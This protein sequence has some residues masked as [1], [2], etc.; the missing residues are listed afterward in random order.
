MLSCCIIY[1]E[2]I[3]SNMAAQTEQSQTDQ[4]TL[5]KS[6]AAPIANTK[7]VPEKDLF[8]WKA[9]SR[10]FKRRD[11]DF[12]MTVVA[13][14]VIFGLI[15]F[16]I[17]GVMPVI[18]IIAIVFLFYVLS[19]VEPEEIEYKITNKGVKIADKR[20][21]WEMFTRFWFSR[22]FNSRLLVFETLALP[23]RLELVVK[24]TD[25]QKLKKILAKYLLEEEAPPSGLDRAANWFSKK[26]PGN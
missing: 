6:E 11:R 17:E 23:G 5:K 15:L 14:A 24:E 2:T 4:G 3:N 1:P 19:T 13:I 7:P 20:T 9:P 26:L 22:R 12:W 8:V 18:L 16:L 10:P 25:T 21:D